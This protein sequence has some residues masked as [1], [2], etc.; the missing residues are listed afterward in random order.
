MGNVL[1]W[2]S[3]SFT[4]HLAVALLLASIVG[5]IATAKIYLTVAALIGFAAFLL[6]MKRMMEAKFSTT[7]D[8]A[9]AKASNAEEYFAENHKIWDARCFCSG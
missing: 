8:P 9:L 4:A 5:I 2:L 1:A 6:Y 7:I 3:Q